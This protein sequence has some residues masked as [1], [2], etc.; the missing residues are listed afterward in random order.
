MADKH[1]DERLEVLA[2]SASSD[3]ARAVEDVA[4]EFVGSG[5]Y[6]SLRMHLASNETILKAFKS[7]AGQMIEE[8]RRYENPDGLREIIDSHLS[9]MRDRALAQ[10][11]SHLHAGKIAPHDREVLCADLQRNM[12]RVRDAVIRDLMFM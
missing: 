1:I 6:G 12:K 3:I 7:A 8:A 2:Q 10:H 9:R 5:G 4:N 11:T